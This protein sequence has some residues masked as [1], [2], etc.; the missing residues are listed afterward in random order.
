[1]VG[2]SLAI[3][4]V[5]QQASLSEAG[6]LGMQAKGNC[7]ERSTCVL[8]RGNEGRGLWAR[9]CSVTDTCAD[10]RQ[11]WMLNPDHAKLIRMDRSLLMP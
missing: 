5:P 10:W 8:P 9:L 1:M 6:T 2:L 3:W 11:H 4:S 7:P